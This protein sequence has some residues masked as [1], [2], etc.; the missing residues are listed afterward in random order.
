MFLEIHNYDPLGFAVRANVSSWYA[1]V[2]ADG[3]VS[4]KWEPKS[5]EDVQSAAAEFVNVLVVLLTPSARLREVRRGNRTSQRILER[6]DG[7]EWRRL[8]RQYSINPLSYF[9]QRC[10]VVRQNRLAKDLLDSRRD[11]AI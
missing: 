4:Y 8:A 3:S 11:V 5:R 6:L 7:L 2:I 10:D 1:L 9:G